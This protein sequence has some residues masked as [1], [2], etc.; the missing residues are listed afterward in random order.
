MKKI[1]FVCTG[2]TCRSPM[3][4]A[5]AHITFSQNNIDI[6]VISRGI[7]VSFP[8]PANENTIKLMKEHYPNI[9]EHNAKQFS[10]NEVD[11]ETVVLT[12]T[13]RHKDFI[14]VSYPS[15]SNKVFTLKEYVDLS[16]D[17]VDPYGS[18]LNVYSN[19][20]NDIGHLINRLVKKIQI[21]EVNK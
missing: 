13:G 17:I 9:L 21:T 15:I 11:E 4:E 5:I 16:G 14:A 12:M 8:S 20:A 18:D 3:A 7:I 6:D 1:I 10:Q 19:C 2:N